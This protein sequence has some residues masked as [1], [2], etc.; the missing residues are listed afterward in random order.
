MK[1]ILRLCLVLSAI[2]VFS[3][4]RAVEP[5]VLYDDFQTS[6][7]DPDKW[8]SSLEPNGI[9]EAFIGISSLYPQLVIQNRAYGDTDT[10]S[11]RVRNTLSLRF[12]G[13][14]AVTA[15]QATVRVEDFEVVGCS[16]PT[17]PNPNTQTFAR[18]A[19]DFFNTGAPSAGDATGDVF[20]AIGIEGSSADPSVLRVVAFVRFCGDST[21]TGGTTASKD[22]GPVAIK[23]FITLRIQW[24]PDNNQFIFQRGTNPEVY[25]PYTVPD[26]NPDTGLL[27]PPGRPVQ[28]LSAQHFV[29]NCDLNANPTLPRPTAF[30][31]ALFD[32]VL[33]NQSA[34]P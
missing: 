34:A 9:L 6:P 23:R 29:A 17:S 12:T 19:G 30:M 4:A 5:L 22:L 1:S 15:I 10:Y 13:R 28:G 14:A 20:A 25:I 26:T 27:I 21:C 31:K 11:G 24:D 16:V 18:L 8:F 3:P 32:N 7:L 2:L 33:V